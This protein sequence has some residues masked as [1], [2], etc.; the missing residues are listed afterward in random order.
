MRIGAPGDAFEAEADRVAE[1]VMATHRAGLLPE[2]RPAAQLVQRRVGAGS[3]EV[4]ETSPLVEEVLHSPG[5]PLGPVER[6]FF[7]S[8][9]GHDFCRV[10]VHADA[11]AAESARSVNASAYTVGE[12]IVFESTQFDPGNPA[13]RKLLAHELTHVVQQGYAA[14]AAPRIQPFQATG[15]PVMQRKLKDIKDYKGAIR[16]ITSLSQAEQSRLGWTQARV[17]KDPNPP[18]EPSALEKHCPVVLAPNT[19]VKVMQ[20]A[21]GG[22]WLFVEHPPSAALGGQRYGFVPGAFVEAVVTSKPANG[23]KV[24]TGGAT[25]APQYS[26][27]RF[28]AQ[29]SA[30]LKSLAEQLAKKRAEAQQRQ[31]QANIG[32]MQVGRGV[33]GNVGGGGAL[34]VTA[35]AVAEPVKDQL[36]AVADA[37]AELQ[38]EIES[39][40]LYTFVAGLVDGVRANLSLEVFANNAETFAKFVVYWN[41]KPSLQLAFLEG[42]A[43]GVKKEIE[44][45]VEL[46]TEFGEV[47]EQ[48]KAL[49]EAIA[50]EGGAEVT[51][52]LG[53]QVGSET[54]KRLTEIGGIT[55]L[56]KLATALGETFGPLLLGIALGIATGGGSAAA[57]VSARMATLL[58][59]FPKLAAF[60]K[61]L[62]GLRKLVPGKKGAAVP[63]AP[64]PNALPK[65]KGKRPAIPS[66]NSLIDDVTDQTR[67]LFKRNPDLK[68]ALTESPRA[69]KALKKCASPCYPEFITRKQIRYLEHLLDSAEDAGIAFDEKKLTDFLRSK[70][71]RAELEGALKALDDDLKIKRGVVG[72]FDDASRLEGRGHE[73]PADRERTTVLRNRPGRASGGEKLPEITGNWFSDV[74]GSKGVRDIRIAQVP[75]QI[76]KKMRAIDHF[77][78]FEDFRQTFWK[79]VS[80][81]PVLNKGWNPS[82]L[83]LMQ[84]GRPPRVGVSHLGVYEGTGGGSNAVYQLNH[85]LALK[86]AGDVYNLDNIEIVTPRTHSA[87]GQ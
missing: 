24:A 10:R 51:R 64:K 12:H 14:P 4:S 71:T 13:G 56:D 33:F 46:V 21:V 2:A 34:Q 39:N 27:E 62:Q 68:N 59:R 87:V 40:P 15:G 3:G 80:Q 78:S 58:A 84:D 66:K 1:Q 61:K 42:T 50:S 49:A 48:M 73:T 41:F 54:A 69:A 26:P 53:Y 63:S 60:I 86:D 47:W 38:K 6:N 17:C 18:A 28:E 36:L 9:F 19:Q 44:G 82:N 30:L 85:R 57:S 43:R 81:D 25:D 23:G 77:D 37:L 5:Q 70:Q 35:Q 76:A 65:P 67:D 32:H 8:R 79:L 7:E 75:G 83:K 74:T 11:R 72:E 22:A 31:M 20:E 29:R 55:D 45:F 52:A 16:P